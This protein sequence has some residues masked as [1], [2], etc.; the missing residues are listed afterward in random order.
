MATV[1]EQLRYHLEGLS[2]LGVRQI[3]GIAAL[4][5][6]FL[7]DPSTATTFQGDLVSFAEEHG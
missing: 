4:V 7:I 3:D 1:D 6:N 5:L 2:A